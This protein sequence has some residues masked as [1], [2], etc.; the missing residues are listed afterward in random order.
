MC[1]TSSP[2]SHQIQEFLWELFPVLNNT[3]SES[4]SISSG[5]CP[6]CPE[7]PLHFPQSLLESVDIFSPK[8]LQ[9]DST[10]AASISF[11][12]WYLQYV[13]YSK[14][15]IHLSVRQ[16]EY[17]VMTHLLPKLLYHNTQ[18]LIRLIILPNQ[19][20]PGFQV[21]PPVS[22]RLPQWNNRVH[23]GVWAWNVL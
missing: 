7:L 21:S 6:S 10:T 23:E 20:T 2:P 22:N 8:H 3:A 5:Q 4:E 11:F 14:F 13:L 16:N 15:L 1:R 12:Y 17:K 18:V 19:S 9:T